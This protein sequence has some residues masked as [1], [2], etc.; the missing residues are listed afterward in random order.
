MG[1]WMNEWMN[2][3]VKFWDVF[4]FY[5]FLSDKVIGWDFV[6]WKSRMVSVKNTGFEGNRVWL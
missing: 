1:E 2:D 5:F 3:L 4:V 6:L